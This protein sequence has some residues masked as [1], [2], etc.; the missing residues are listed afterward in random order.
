MDLIIYIR[1]YS[2]IKSRYYKENSIVLN[3]NTLTLSEGTFYI[4]V[5]L[6][7]FYLRTVLSTIYRYIS[8]GRLLYAYPVYTSN[9]PL[10]NPSPF[11]NP[12]YPF[13]YFYNNYTFSI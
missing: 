5:I 4:Y 13:N 3:R 7:F 10:L 2:Y 11:L 6:Y 12:S 9:S 1:L 8:A